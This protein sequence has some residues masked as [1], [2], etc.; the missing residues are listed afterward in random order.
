[1]KRLFTNINI[2]CGMSD[3]EYYK[4][5]VE[6]LKKCSWEKLPDN[7]F[8]CVSVDWLTFYKMAAIDYR[9]FEEK[10]IAFRYEI[11]F[12][13][14]SDGQFEYEVNF[15]EKEERQYSDYLIVET[16][17]LE[18]FK[19]EEKNEDLSEEEIIK[20]LS[21]ALTLATDNLDID[22]I[23]DLIDNN[24]ADVSNRM[25][26]IFCEN[27]EV[28]DIGECLKDDI[29]KDWIERNPDDAYETAVDNM[30]S[31]E[32]KDKIIDYLSDNL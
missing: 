24:F 30:D 29:A 16:D 11:F 26:E 12:I 25:R 17:D 15:Y 6:K 20:K 32:I 9:Y 3:N 13:K 27:L 21:S 22:R 2:N 1:M 5:I 10:N 14:L 7:K 18:L 19:V 23:I 4:S 28:D 8:L 31:Y